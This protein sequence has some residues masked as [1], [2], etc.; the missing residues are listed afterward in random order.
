[1]NVSRGDPLDTLY[2]CPL[3][4]KY[5]NQGSYHTLMPTLNKSWLNEWMST[6]DE[7]NKLAIN[8]VKEWHQFHFWSEFLKHLNDGVGLRTQ[9]GDLFLVDFGKRNMLTV[10]PAAGTQFHSLLSVHSVLIQGELYPMTK[11]NYKLNNLFFWQ[12]SIIIKHFLR[13]YSHL[14]TYWPPAHSLAH[15]KCF[16]KWLIP[17]M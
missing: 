9:N 12:I 5:P 17:T 13:C 1:M 8:L 10:Q 4:G 16:V 2:K 11:K 7:E 15:T 6:L 14:I 3:P